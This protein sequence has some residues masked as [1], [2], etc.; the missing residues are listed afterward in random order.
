[1]RLLL[2]L[3][4]TSRLSAADSTTPGEVTTPFPTMPILIFPN[5]LNPDKYVVL[6]SGPTFREDALLNNSQQIPKLPDWSFI[7][8]NT[9]PDGKWPGKVLE[10]G[11]FDEA[12][13]VK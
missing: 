13:K 6:N 4:L 7:D 12:W 11:F 2:F 3:L 1:M 9:A 5:P 8:V 10:A